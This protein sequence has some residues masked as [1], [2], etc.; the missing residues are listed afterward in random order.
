MRLLLICLLDELKAIA[1]AY[2]VQSVKRLCDGLANPPQCHEMRA[3]AGA[4]GVAMAYAIT[5]AAPAAALPQ[6]K[7]REEMVM[8]GKSLQVKKKVA[9]SFILQKRIKTDHA[10][11]HL[12]QSQDQCLDI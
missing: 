1:A 10:M 5:T 3:G 9:A 12:M 2:R 7:E 11:I 6:I 8:L 4:A